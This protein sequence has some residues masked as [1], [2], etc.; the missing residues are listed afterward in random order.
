MKVKSLTIIAAVAAAA[1]ICGTATAQKFGKRNVFGYSGSTRTVIDSKIQMARPLRWAP[2]DK[3]GN[4]IGPWISMVLD[5]DWPN[6]PWTTI[7]DAIEL[8]PATLV[9]PAPNGAPFENPGYGPAYMLTGNYGLL[10]NAPGAR[11]RAPATFEMTFWTNDME[12]NP[13]YAGF[14]ANRCSI[15]WYW[16]PVGGAGTESCIININNAETFADTAVGLPPPSG[17][18]NISWGGAF[19]GV[20]LDFGM[21]LPVGGFYANIDLDA[22][23]TPLSMEL[24]GDGKGAYIVSIRSAANTLASRAQPYFWITKQTNYGLPGGNPSKQGAFEWDDDTDIASTLPYPAGYINNSDGRHM[25]D[26]PGPAYLVEF[27]DYTGAIG[28]PII[29]PLGPAFGLYSNFGAFTA[30]SESEVTVDAG[31]F[32]G[33]AA[34]S[35]RIAGDNDIYYVLCDEFDSIGTM[36]FTKDTSAVTTTA[37]SVIGS[38]RA[39]RNDLSEFWQFRNFSTN[40]WQNVGIRNSPL[41]SFVSNRIDVTTGAANFLDGNGTLQF[42][43]LWVPQNDVSDIDGWTMMVDRLTVFVK[44]TD[45]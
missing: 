6:G 10:A 44:G 13:L 4:Q 27:Y 20:A 12:V 3:F 38:T 24:P 26:P 39:S 5:N 35:L 37:I 14:D 43:Y 15:M 7:F 16:N 42:R 17:P 40:A 25:T 31:L 23:A 18:N 36:R 21:T 19:D 30:T 2:I 1:M 29:E 34:S 8:S 32:F 41:G 45:D 22:G 28:P 11:F 33:G 9:P